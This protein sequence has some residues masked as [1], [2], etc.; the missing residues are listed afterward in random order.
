MATPAQ[1]TKVGVFLTLCTILIAGG[2]IYVAGFRG[3]DERAYTVVFRENVLGLSQG[4]VVQYEGV[5]VGSVEDIIVAPDHT[6]HVNILVDQGKV[7]LYPGVKAVLQIYS[8][9][10]GTMTVALSGGDSPGDAEVLPEGSLIEAQPSLVSAF[11]S[12]AS[13]IMDGIRDFVDRVNIGLE[14]MEKGELTKVIRNTDSTIVELRATAQRIQTLADDASKQ[15]NSLSGGVHDTV[16]EINT[17][18]QKATE[19]AGNAND[20]VLAVKSKIEPLD[21]N[22]T[23]NELQAEI[24]RLG[25]QLSEL[26]NSMND[27]T[28]TIVSQGD[29]VQYNSVETMKTLNE[30]LEAVQGLAQYLHDNPSSLLRGRGKSSEEE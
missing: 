15:I 2:L 11:S 9:A 23:V 3:K 18:A 12:Q 20:T 16:E 30:T 5:I 14:G 21:L 24:N 13:E 17:F 28:K 7:K 25:A 22:K 27:A 26:A 4:S 8:L 19:L 10:A 29:N 6:V 1:K